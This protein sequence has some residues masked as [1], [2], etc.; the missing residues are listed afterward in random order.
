M[1]V[2]FSVIS[3]F[4]AERRRA[5]LATF[6]RCNTD[7]ETFRHLPLEP[8]HWGYS[9][10][11]VP[12]LQGRIDFLESLLPIFNTVELL[13]HRQRV[14]DEIRALRIDIEREKRRDFIRD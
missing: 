9:G 1:A 5:R 13:P 14:E 4:S 11:A 3:E 10:S 12:M 7:P 6:L 2:L 8:N